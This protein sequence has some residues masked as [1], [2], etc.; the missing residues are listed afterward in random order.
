MNVN[1]AHVSK[2]N[3]TNAIAAGVALAAAFGIAIPSEYQALAT[4]VVAVGAPIVTIILRTFF[5]AKP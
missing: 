1:P 3:W 5:T 4:Q 2:I